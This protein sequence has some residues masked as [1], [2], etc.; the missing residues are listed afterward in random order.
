MV[1]GT[2]W[3]VVAETHALI[4]SRQGHA[5]AGRCL[6]AF[7]FPCVPVDPAD[8]A[9]ARRMVAAHADQDYSLCDAISCAVLRRLG[10]RAAFTF[11]RHFATRASP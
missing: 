6:A 5:R 7:H 8:M 4:L 11:D 3:F 1:V 2:T 9:A 10:C